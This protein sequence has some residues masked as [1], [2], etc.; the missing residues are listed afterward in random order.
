MSTVR[1]FMSNEN[2]KCGVGR[3]WETWEHVPRTHSVSPFCSCPSVEGCLDT[4]RSMRGNRMTMLCWVPC[5]GLWSK[6]ASCAA[7][8]VSKGSWWR[9]VW[10]RRKGPAALSSYTKEVGAR[11][12]WHLGSQIARWGPPA[13]RGTEVRGVHLNQRQ[14]GVTPRPSVLCSETEIAWRTLY[15][16]WDRRG[17]DPSHPTHCLGEVHARQGRAS[18]DWKNQRTPCR[19]GACPSSTPNSPA[20]TPAFCPREE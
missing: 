4:A 17:R 5:R 9:V 6:A 14:V 19:F 13:R 16:C 7:S 20:P 8:A 10:L 15:P 1:C 12:R 3:R 2:R 11:S 18:R